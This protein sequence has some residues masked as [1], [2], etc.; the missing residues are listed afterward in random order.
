M[1]SDGIPQ[2]KMTC[3]SGGYFGSIRGENVG[4]DMETGFIS[5]V[6]SLNGMHV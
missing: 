2:G 6:D 4:F 5:H 1:F 3:I